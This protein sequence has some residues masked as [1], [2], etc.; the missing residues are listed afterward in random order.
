MSF[1]KILKYIKNPKQI[2][3]VLIQKYLYL[4]NLP[5]EKHIKIE[6]KNIFGREPDLEKPQTFNEKM[7]WLKLYD[8]KDIYTSM[9]DKYEAKKYVANMIGEEY[10]IPNLGIYYNFNEID[11]NS[12]PNQFVIK[13][14]HDSG[15]VIICKNKKEFDIKRAKRKIEKSLKKNF[16]RYHKE[17]PYKNVKPRILIEEFIGENLTDYRIYCFNG[18]PQYIYMYVSEN[19]NIYKPEPI[20]CNIY[21]T[22]W[23][24]QKFR[25]KS[26][27]S[28]KIYEKPQE[29]DKMLDLAK[30]LSKDTKFLRVDFYLIKGKILY[31]ELTFFPG[32]G[33]SE[34][35]PENT[36]LELGN[37]IKLD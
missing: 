3:S 23:I 28:K 20:I 7:Q 37:L 10:I 6:Y 11:F 5:D 22:N 14:T 8:R 1:N 12:L 17:W 31:G 27:Q 21:D 13:C 36:D 19:D 33:I 4:L 26:P 18:N 35:Y 16:Y 32:G 15:G 29:L 34:F 25:Q 30:K 9:V 2:K 24:L